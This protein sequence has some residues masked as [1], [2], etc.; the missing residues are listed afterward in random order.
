[1]LE[2]RVLVV[3]DNEMVRQA[4]RLRLQSEPRLIFVGELPDTSRL[5]DEV[6]RTTPDIVVLD[7]DV[8]GPEPLE[9]LKHLSERFTGVRVIILSGTISPSLLDKAVEAGAWGYLSKTTDI[10]NVMNGIARVAAGEFVLDDP[11][12]S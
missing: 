4:L 11:E 5:L 3:D 8:P 9:L 10:S 1:M 12:C 6:A 7:Y 2:I